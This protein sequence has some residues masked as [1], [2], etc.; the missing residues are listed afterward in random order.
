MWGRYAPAVH[1]NMLISLDTFKKYRYS[2]IIT[3]RT[4]VT[5]YDC[6]KTQY[7]D[8]ISDK[9]VSDRIKYMSLF[10]AKTPEEIDRLVALFPELE[11]VRHDI[12]EYLVRPKEVLNMWFDEAVI[13]QI[14]PLGLCG[15][16]LVNNGGECEEEAGNHRILRIL[17]W[18]DHIKSMGTSC[19]LFNPLFES[20][21]HGYDTRNYNKVDRR[22]G[23]NE[24]FKKVC[25][26]IH[27]S[28]MKVMLDG[29]FNHAGRGFF[30]FE[31]VRQKKWDSRYKDWFH[32]SFDGNTNYN[33]GFWYES[34]EG[35]NELVKLNLS[36]PEVKEYLFD[37]VKN[38]V[39]E[40]DIDGLRLDVAYCLDRQFLSELRHFTD[41]LKNEFV[42]MGE[43]LHGDYNQWVNDNACYSV[44]NYECYKGIYSSFNSSNM[45][46]IAY[47]LNRQFGNEQ[48]CIYRGKHLF[49][50]VDNHD[51]ARIASQ[52]TDLE[53]LPLI[54]GML[55][56]LPGIPCIY[57]GSEWGQTGKKE[58]GSD[59]SLRPEY[60]KPLPNDL[61]EYIKKLVEIRNKYKALQL[62]E[63]NER[64]LTNKQFVFERV[65][66][67]Q[68]IIIALNLDENEYTISLNEQKAHSL[69]DNISIDSLNNVILP[70][71]SIQYYLIEN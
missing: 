65:F 55:F 21:A 63:Y 13:Y 6:D 40:Y 36:N 30:A 58:Q 47:S 69:I 48:W 1:I 54:Y 8:G 17:D 52:L 23:T 66:E 60:E 11:S 26:A 10:V 19:V 39:N 41:G 67:N 31:D 71:K 2:D 12:N 9:M 3:G 7:S 50:F 20:D 34:W 68:K 38:W 46:E 16:P 4:N 70:P 43:T 28:G 64:I 42:L 44:T 49:S 18:I 59:A 45:H 22:L 14:Y 27:A 32:I 5:E 37:A 51:V 35:C 61:T 62:G 29:V 24:D 25:D 53:K 56:S 33:D 57:Y 15:A